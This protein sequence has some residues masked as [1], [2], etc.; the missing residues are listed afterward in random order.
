MANYA[1]EII[2]LEAGTDYT[3]TFIRTDR[4]MPANQPTSL[5]YVQIGAASQEG[6]SKGPLFKVEFADLTSVG[7]E[8]IKI[9]G[10]QNDDMNAP[11]YPIT[12]LNTWRPII[13]IYLKKFIFCTIDGTPVAET[14]YTVIGYKKNTM[15][16]VY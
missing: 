1:T 4:R 14:D 7:A 6:N 11:I 8:Y 15:P 9:W 16:T 10:L 3:P 13:D 12:Y 5:G 2:Q